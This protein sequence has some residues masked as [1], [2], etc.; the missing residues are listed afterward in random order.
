[1]NDEDQLLWLVCA[2]CCTFGMVVILNATKLHPLIFG[3]LL[4]FLGY[5][6]MKAT[7]RSRP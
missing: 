5:K 1:M 4:V 6:G 3:L 2:L 7:W